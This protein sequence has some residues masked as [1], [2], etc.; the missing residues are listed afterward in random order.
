MSPS[1]FS[2]T[3][4]T[5]QAVD[6]VLMIILGITVALLVLI[7]FLLVFFVI[8]YSRKRHPGP[9]ETKEHPWL[10]IAWTVAP[11]ILVLAMFYYGVVGYDILRN[12]P[13]NAM[14]V[15]VTARQWSWLFTYENGIKSTTLR[16]PL[17]RPVKLLLFSQDVIHG[18]YVPAFRI[19]Q[20]VVPG[21]ENYV[22]FQATNPGTYDVFCTQYCGLEHAHMLSKVEVLS[23]N[24]FASWYQSP[25]NVVAGM[26][27]GARLYSEKGCIGCH[28]LDGSSRVGPSFKGLYGST[29]MVIRNGKEVTVTVD[30]AYCK[31]YILA[32][33]QDVVKGYPPI[34]PSQKG[35]LTDEELKELVDYLEE[36]K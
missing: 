16:V 22:W 3:G 6:H 10:E 25:Q 18:F 30:E 5:G 28:S 20:D 13:R 15:R 2:S 26:S 29:E 12:V 14:L 8:R 7:T 27:L 35:Q 1:L 4:I 11:T 36:L 9:D 32:P 21:M 31:S 23:Q 33:N 17:G 34:M 24:D 19:K